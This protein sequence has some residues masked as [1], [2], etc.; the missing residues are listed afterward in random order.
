MHY[1]VCQKGLVASCTG[2]QQYSPPMQI[3]QTLLKYWPR[4]NM[5]KEIAFLMLLQSVV[6]HVPSDVLRPV[7]P[8]IERK[9]CACCAGDHFL[10]GVE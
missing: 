3:I 7:A 6:S 8:V 10:V 1:R 2:T 9:L 4:G 5:N